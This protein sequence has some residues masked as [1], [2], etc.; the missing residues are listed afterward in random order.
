[1]KQPNY[2]IV[3]I[4]PNRFKIQVEVPW[5]SKLVFWDKDYKYWADTNRNGDAY[6]VPALPIWTSLYASEAF[7][8]IE[9]AY[10]QLL[11]WE[12]EHVLNQLLQIYHTREC[13][14]KKKER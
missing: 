14:C 3:Q 12:R 5:R 4:K 13:D 10:E 6:K 2:R 11:Q 1:M 7:Y 8:T 9:K